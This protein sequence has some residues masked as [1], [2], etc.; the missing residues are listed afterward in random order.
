MEYKNWTKEDDEFIKKYYPE[1]G[2]SFCSIKLNVNKR[3]ISVRA[4]KLGVRML[5]EFKNQYSIKY[6]KEILEHAVKKS[7]CYADVCRNVGIIPQAGNF[8]NIRKRIEQYKI[9]ISHFL[10]P[11]ELTSIRYK[12]D[13]QIKNNDG[14]FVKKSVYDYLTL[15]SNIDS[16]KLKEKLYNEGLKTCKCEECGQGEIWR[17]K[18]MSLI[19]DHINGK[20]NDNR[21]ENLRILCPNCNATLPT[22]CSKNRKNKWKV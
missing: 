20:N 3:K 18:K 2:P 9:D 17:G 12:K 19:L 15:E 11:A 7:L 21:L 5:Q 8:G 13:K 10:T 14:T 1:N 16:S 22:H 4:K 6:T